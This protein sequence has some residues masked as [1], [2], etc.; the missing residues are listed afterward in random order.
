MNA[1]ATSIELDRSAADPAPEDR[2][3]ADMYALIAALFYGPPSAQL[4]AMLAAAPALTGEGSARLPAAWERLQR[5]AACANA[6]GLRQEYDAC[7]I[8]IGEAPVMLYGS[9]YLT[10]YLHEKPLADLRATLAQLGLARKDE[11]REPEDHIAAVADVMRHLILSG[12]GGC[13]AERDFFNR[14]LRPWYGRLAERVE[15]GTESEFYLALGGFTRAF[16]DVE[17]E[18]FDLE[19]AS[20][21]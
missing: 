18:S 1:S 21:R 5:A 17:R 19:V 3:R 16:L 7:F 14:F 12:E 20:G 4:L 11:A 15:Q 13:D 6:E 10:G 8:S 9:H 2:A